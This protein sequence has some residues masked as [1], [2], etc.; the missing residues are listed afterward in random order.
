MV[1]QSANRDL[2]VRPLEL[3]FDIAIVGAAVR[4]DAKAAEGIPAAA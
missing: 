3:P 4:L 1:F 2:L